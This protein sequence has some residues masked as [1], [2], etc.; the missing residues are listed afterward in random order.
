MTIWN[1]VAWLEG[2]C[3]TPRH[4]FVDPSINKNVWFGFKASSGWVQSAFEYNVDEHLTFKIVIGCAMC[5]FIIFVVCV[6]FRSHCLLAFAGICFSNP[7][8]IFPSCSCRSQWLDCFPYFGRNAQYLLS[9]S[10]FLWYMQESPFR[11]WATSTLLFPSLYW[12]NTTKYYL[13]R[14]CLTSYPKPMTASSNASLVINYPLFLFSSLDILNWMNM[15]WI[16]N[17]A[18]S[19]AIKLSQEPIFSPK[20]LQNKPT[21]PEKA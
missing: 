17:V 12:R 7:P 14:R 3:V 11:L 5:I 2:G 9:K 13:G 16:L 19:C 8:L 18:Y 10:C 15:T 6:L 1:Q 21:F 4:N 20:L